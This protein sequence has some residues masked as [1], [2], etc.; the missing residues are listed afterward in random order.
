MAEFELSTSIDDVTDNLLRL[1][2]YALGS[3][4]ERDFHFN[5]VYNAEHQVF[6]KT[7]DGPIFAPVKWCGAKGNTIERYDLRKRKIS[8]VFQRALSNM[9]FKPITEGQTTYDEIYR[10]FIDFCYGFNFKNSEAGLPHS[11]SSR[12]RQFWSLGYMP[13]TRFQ[14]FSD[15]VSDPENY[16]EGATKTISVNSYERN[17]KAR[18]A[19]VAH[20]GWLC[21]ACHINFQDVYG[22]I[23]AQFIHV[24]HVRPLHEIGE[25][26]KVD[27]IAD[28]RPL[29]P[30][31][32][33]MIHRGKSALTVE[34]LSAL[35]SINRT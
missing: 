28:L 22:D 32:H 33:A 11:N 35:I 30:N 8:Q 12:P 24:H 2:S 26:Y 1:H 31:C 27:P 4:R 9:G 15:E 6:Y 29:C 16:F 19:C 3:Q 21:Q 23:G 25:K 20:Y 34:E 17:A 7:A 10:E 14:N 5:R 18:L 13:E